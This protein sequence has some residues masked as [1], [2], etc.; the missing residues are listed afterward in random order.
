M[1][2]K[3]VSLIVISALFLT[4]AM[5]CSKKG[6]GKLA[7]L[8]IK[9]A[10]MGY[11]NIQSSLKAPLLK[12][13]NFKK[14]VDNG[15]KDLNKQMARGKAVKNFFDCMGIKDANT[16]ISK[17]KAAAFFSEN[18]DLK[19]LDAPTFPTEAIAIISTDLNGK[20]LISCVEKNAP[21]HKEK[22]MKKQGDMLLLLDN[23]ATVALL[24]NG[25]III[26]AGKNYKGHVKLGSGILGK[27]DLKAA[28][29]GKLPDKVLIFKATDVKAPPTTAAM[30]IKLDKVDVD[31]YLHIS[32]GVDFAINID[33]KNA[34]NAKKLAELA[35][36]YIKIGASAPQAAAFKDI[37][38]KIK[39]SSAGSVFK[40]GLKL[41]KEDIAKITAMAG[42]MLMHV[43]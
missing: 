39:I 38:N 7:K 15:I 43:L 37:I 36:S 19:A 14:I 31:G 28:F 29:G 17:F 13:G 16:L 22:Y 2:T 5:S 9:P 25:N 35:Q 24:P 32:S 10:L 6:S 27:G 4:G 34:D 20:K 40:T 12:E 3:K 30:G 21:K 42:P 33:V 23:D 18:P 8:E 11:V 26:Y 41:S 1:Y